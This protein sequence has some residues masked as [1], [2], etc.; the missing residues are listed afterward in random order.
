MEKTLSIDD[1]ANFCKRRGFVYPTAE[2]YGGL[3]G[4]WDFGPVGSELK[5]N[6]KDDWWKFHVHARDDMAGIDGSII[7][8]A[9][10]WEASGHVENFCD[11]AVVCKNAKI[12]SKS[13]KTN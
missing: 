1:L 8:N 3:A 6:I 13:T 12:S 11:Y 4:F 9:K 2:I 7:T 5:K 10:V